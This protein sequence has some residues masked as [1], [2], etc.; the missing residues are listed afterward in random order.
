[1]KHLQMVFD[2]CKLKK[3]KCQF[4]KKQVEYLGHMV[5]IRER[6]SDCGFRSSP[7]LELKIYPL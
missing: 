3:S 1:M 4:F 6:F 2:V 5:S 7:K